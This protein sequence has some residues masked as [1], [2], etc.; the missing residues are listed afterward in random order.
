MGNIESST[1]VRATETILLVEDSS[2]ARKA[3]KLMFEALGYSVIEAV[4]GEDALKKFRSNRDKIQLV[5]LD[6]ILPQG[7]SKPV[8]DEM[9][10]IRSDIKAIFISGYTEDI[11][12]KTGMIEEGLHFLAKP[13]MPTELAI[14]IKEVLAA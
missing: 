14:K 12:K 9:R 1:N 5:M 10:A 4:D 7:S 6:V 13:F 2:P 3:T 8:Y 11:L